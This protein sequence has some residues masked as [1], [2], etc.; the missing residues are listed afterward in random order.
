MSRSEHEANELPNLKTD[1]V[2]H[3]GGGTYD[4]VS[5]D[6]V[7]TI[8][9]NV[10]SRTFQVNGQCKVIGNLETEE[11]KCDGMLNVKGNA[12]VV[13]GN[14]GGMATIEGSLVGEQVELYGLLKVKKDCEIER[15]EADGVFLIDGHLHA[16]TVDVHLH[17]LSRAS[18]IGGESI[19]VRRESKSKWNLLRLFRKFS[20][21]LRAKVIEGDDLDLEYTSAEIVRGNR[22]TIGE[23]CSIGRVEY[24][25]ELK[26][27]PAAKVREEEKLGG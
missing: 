21:E 8:N 7:S 16:G 23:G 22:V 5:L 3:A 27:H 9:G 18:E 1:G 10:I 17:G 13:K 20:P 4:T 26:K 12:Q 11:M 19:R 14:V 25:Q 2:S 6:G 15:F 24:R